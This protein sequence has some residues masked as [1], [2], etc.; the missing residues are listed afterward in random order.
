MPSPTENRTP[1]GPCVLSVNVSP[2][3]APQRLVAGNSP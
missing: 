3:G 2:G 1:S